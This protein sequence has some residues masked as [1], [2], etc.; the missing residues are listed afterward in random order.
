MPFVGE[1]GSKLK[2]PVQGN[3][4]NIGMRKSSNLLI[5]FLFLAMLFWNP[6]S[7]QLYYSQQP[8]MESMAVHAIFLI[9]P[10]ACLLLIL[11]V[12][13]SSPSQKSV[14]LIF[15]CSWFLLLIGM[16]ILGNVMLGL[17]AGASPS[18]QRN[19]GFI[20]KPNTRVVYSSPEFNF[21]VKVNHLGLRDDEI[22]PSKKDRFRILC[23]GDS[24]T[25]GWG[26]RP[27]ESWPKQLMQRL[28]DQGFKHV[29]VINCGQPGVY[30]SA[31]LGYMKK[32]LPRLK[33]D[34]ILVGVLQLDDLAQLYEAQHNRNPEKAGIS[35]E[36]V[37]LTNN[38]LKSSFGNYAQ[39]LEKNSKNEV[40]YVKDIWIEKSTEFMDGLQGSRLLRFDR[41]DDSLKWMFVR[42]ELNPTLLNRYIDF[43]DR[44]F[45]F[46]N[47]EHPATKDAI[48]LMSIDLK[49]MKEVAAQYNARIVFVNM[50]YNQ[51]TG[52]KVIRMPTDELD[53]YLRNNNRIDSIY[54]KLALD[55]G[56]DYIE[57][58][59]YF[60][61]LNPKDSF[62]FK[63]DGHPTRKGYNA[64]ADYISEALIQKGYINQP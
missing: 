1:R 42:G 40:L 4:P 60:S 41:L 43:P 50:P 32:I 9:I 51:F 19:D 8:A 28:H 44:P 7:H 2:I 56:M 34:L 11:F 47:P 57:L 46:N 18:N 38:F 15:G 6:L 64:M 21:D 12:R 16:L 62:F 33:A 14:N 61:K 36:I 10:L 26:V 31:Y 37:N 27:E 35:H 22:D 52:H 48:N 39:I 24:W 45:I 29:E 3:H 49:G 13:Q 17:V 58:T 5:F 59:D 30:T 55:N 54:R 23:F 53:E 63:Y 20:F 25:F